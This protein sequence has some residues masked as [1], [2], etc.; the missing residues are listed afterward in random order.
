[1]PARVHGNFSGRG[2]GSRL[3][4]KNGIIYYASSYDGILKSEDNGESWVSYY[5][6]GERCMT[7]IHADDSGKRIIASSAGLQNMPSDKMRGHSLLF[8]MTV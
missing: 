1:M 4:V 7:F 3:T 6:F 8:P 2:T 5:P